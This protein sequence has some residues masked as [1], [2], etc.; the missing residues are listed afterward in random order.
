MKSK[1]Q[2][3]AQKKDESKEIP[4][5]NEPEHKRSDAVDELEL[6]QHQS[7]SD[8]SYSENLDVTPPKPHEF[9][10]IGIAE[11]DF[12]TRD[13]GRTTGRMIDHEPGL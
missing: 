9:P 6:E 3:S 8:G 10:S 2:K 5:K 4:K 7:S 12:V 11:T 13:H 1:N